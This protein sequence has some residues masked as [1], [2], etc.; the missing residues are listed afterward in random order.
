MSLVNKSSKYSY[1]GK[2]SDDGEPPSNNLWVGNLSFDVTDSDLMNLFSKYGAVD[3]ITTYPLRCFG[4]VYF[5]RVEDAKA[6]RDALRGTY[7]RG[8]SL[9][10]E[11]A[12]P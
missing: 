11:F 12:R 4:F 9:K 5:K 10:I 1:G 8:N 6:A 7:L 3:S 2:V